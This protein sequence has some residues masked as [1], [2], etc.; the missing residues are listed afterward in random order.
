MKSAYIVSL[1][2]HLLSQIF[3]FPLIYWLCDFKLLNYSE[4]VFQSAKLENPIMWKK[5]TKH[6]HRMVV[7][8]KQ[9]YVSIK[10]YL[11]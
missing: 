1:K 8:F 3:A 11:K 4:S 5:N 9:N 10:A 6:P 2:S 7:K